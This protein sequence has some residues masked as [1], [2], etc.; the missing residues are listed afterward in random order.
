M[1]DDEQQAAYLH[2]LEAQFE[3]RH[4]LERPLNFVEW[5]GALIILAVLIV[6]LGLLLLGALKLGEWL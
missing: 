6:W 5:T 2:D 4:E 1:S 3:A